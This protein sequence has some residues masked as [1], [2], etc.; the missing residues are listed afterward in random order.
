M[1]GVAI[2]PGADPPPETNERR[3]GGNRE[4]R[5][6]RSD[7]L[8]GM[9]AR[10]HDNGLPGVPSATPGVSSRWFHV[11]HVRERFLQQTLCEAT[12]LYWRRRADEFDAARSRPGDYAGAATPA[13]IAA[14]DAGLAASAQE[15]RLAAELAPLQAG[16][17]AEMVAGVLAEV[18]YFDPGETA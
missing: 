17:S 18:L 10:A 6:V 9:P 13:E 2:R 1:I 5:S 12:A 4:R 3:P 11:G 7:S 8:G 16:A 14:R 15:C